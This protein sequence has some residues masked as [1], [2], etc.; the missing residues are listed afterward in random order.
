M[1]GPGP[2]CLLLDLNKATDAAASILGH[3]GGPEKLRIYL[4][5]FVLTKLKYAP[6]VYT[7][8]RPNKVTKHTWS[9]SQLERKHTND[10]LTILSS[11]DERGQVKKSDT[12]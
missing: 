1:R 11:D 2:S 5:P 3:R 4:L 6:M 12:S 7:H 8:I 10:L 9:E